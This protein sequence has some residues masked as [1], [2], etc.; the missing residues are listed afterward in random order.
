ME[1]N[2]EKTLLT[3][4]EAAL[5]TGI[6]PGTVRQWVG[7]GRIDA[8]KELIDGHYTLLL[9]RNKVLELLKT[10]RGKIHTK[11]EIEQMI[12]D[13]RERARIS[14]GRYNQLGPVTDRKWN[15]DKP[16]PEMDK[17]KE[18]TKKRKKQYYS[19]NREKINEHAK[20]YRSENKEKINEYHKK[21]NSE[22]RDKLSERNKDYR[23][24][25]REKLNEYQRKYY[26]KNKEKIKEQRRKH[27]AEKIREEEM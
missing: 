14:W 5:L 23:S 11:D 3:V 25:N 18:K 1:L 24:E 13:E 10:F 15:V 6:N 20:K 2:Y 22:N 17:T 12:C 21:Y 16:V 7:G 27:H 8:K 9:E 19:K 26:S 4:N